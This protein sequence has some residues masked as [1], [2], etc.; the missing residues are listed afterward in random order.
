MLDYKGRKLKSAGPSTPVRNIR[1][2]RSTKCRDEFISVEDEKLT[3]NCRK[4]QV[5]EA[6]RKHKCS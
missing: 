4:D 1:F 5:G 6:F 3:T 2:I